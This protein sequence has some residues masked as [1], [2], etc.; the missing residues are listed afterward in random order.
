MTKS[1]VAAALG[2]QQRWRAARRKQIP[3]VT[4]ELL[5]QV[6]AELAALRAANRAAI[7]RNKVITQVEARYPQDQHNEILRAMFGGVIPKKQ[8]VDATRSVA[9]AKK[10]KQMKHQLE[11]QSEMVEIIGRTADK[12]FTRWSIHQ[13]KKEMVFE[14]SRNDTQL[15]AVAQ[16]FGFR[17]KQGQHGMRLLASQRNLR[18]LPEIVDQLESTPE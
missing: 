4:P 10:A 17:R 1:V 5:A 9:L 15:I 13:Q 7:N 8:P 6:E 14:C 3:D 2:E 18:R 12:R 11:E 16:S